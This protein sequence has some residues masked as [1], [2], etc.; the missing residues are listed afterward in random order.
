MKVKI[1][2][3]IAGR[4]P[5]VGPFANSAGDVVAIPDDLAESLLRA[6]HARPATKVKQKPEKAKRQAVKVKRE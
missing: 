4:Q 3:G 1:L 5:E 2:R 6:G